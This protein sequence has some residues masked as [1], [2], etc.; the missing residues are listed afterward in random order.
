MATL[1][2]DPTFIEGFIGVLQKLGSAYRTSRS[3]W[4]AMVVMIYDYVLSFEEEVE[5]MWRGRFVWPRLLFWLIR[6]HLCVLRQTLAMLSRV[7]YASVIDNR[8]TFW[9]RWFMYATIITRI[10]ISAILILRLH[11]VYKCNRKL[12]LGLC[13]LFVAELSVECVILAKIFYNLQVIPV[14]I[15]SQVPPQV[16]HG[17]TGCIPASIVP[18]A[19]AYWIPVFFFE[20]VLFV[21]SAYKCLQYA[22]EDTKSPYLMRVL[23]RDSIM[24]FGGVL[25]AILL[26]FVI[27]VLQIERLFVAFIPS[28]HIQKAARRYQYRARGRTQHGNR[29]AFVIDI[30]VP[31]AEHGE[32]EHPGFVY[33]PDEEAQDLID[34][35]LD[36]PTPIPLLPIHRRLP[37][38]YPQTV[39]TPQF[40]RL[41]ES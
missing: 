5:Y 9:W 10:S 15:L 16:V 36:A 21:L 27:W 12:S 17:I 37:S 32:E 20:S 23:L 4:S 11:V 18:Y 14:F 29:R 2:A 8:C 41:R 1:A 24:Y 6:Q 13:A 35:V 33:E 25:S 39:L 3:F 40:A 26:N 19:W 34:T 7:T 31:E 38:M 28:L 30:A 22:R